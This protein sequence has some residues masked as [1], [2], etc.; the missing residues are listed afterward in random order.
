MPEKLLEALRQY[1]PK[2]ASEQ[3]FRLKM[4]KLLEANGTKAF[5]RS[6]Y[7]AHFTASGWL[8]NSEAS[9]ALL[10]HH[11]KLNKWLQPGGHAD[12]E[13]DLF[14]VVC[15]E[16]FEETGLQYFNQIEDSVFDIDIHAIPARPNKPAH[17]HYDV[18]FLFITRPGDQVVI[19]GESLSFK[20]IELENIASLTDNRSIKRMAEKS[21]ILI[22][23]GY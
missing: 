2:D 1:M 3:E 16:V 18:R 17:E 8:I 6:T 22:H 20:W 4:I 5:N 21:L 14:K 13:T 19:N 11:K 12:G 9:K 23:D 15:K 10:I 7:P